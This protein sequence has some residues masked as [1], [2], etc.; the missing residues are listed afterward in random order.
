MELSV[1]EVEQIIPK[2]DVNLHQVQP[3]T[4]E[5]EKKLF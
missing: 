2:K 5:E 1:E 4:A 3:L